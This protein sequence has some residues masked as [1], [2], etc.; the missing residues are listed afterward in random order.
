MIII[1]IL[2]TFLLC[3][4]WGGAVA[5]HANVNSS[6]IKHNSNPILTIRTAQP[7]RK[8][9]TKTVWWTGTVRSVN[10]AKVGSQQDG[11]IKKIYV[12]DNAAVKKGDKI[13]L[14]G[15]VSI[16]NQLHQLLSKSDLI[17]QK[18]TLTK[19]I[20]NNKRQAVNFHVLPT[21]ELLQAKIQLKQLQQQRKSI[22]IQIENIKS[23][24]IITSPIDGVFS[25]RKV[26]KGQ[27]VSK[28]TTLANV[29]DTH[30][31]RIIAKTFTHAQLRGCKAEFDSDGIKLTG[32][33]RNVLP[34]K[35]P[36]G[37]AIIYI[38]SNEIN[39]HCQIGQTLSGQIII[40]K[41]PTLAIPK[42]AM[43]YDDNENA[44]VFIETPTGKYIKHK[45]KTGS[46]SGKFIEIVSGIK[47][48]D[49][50]VVEGAYELFFAHFNKIYKVAD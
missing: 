49:K 23:Q 34:R 8:K 38:T 3:V 29:I 25:N 40:G 17:Q 6:N 5:L 11:I 20:L 30:H 39:R 32:I 1:A 13:F 50:I 18:I 9:F 42:S 27:L 28:F 35:T 4:Y 43:V 10:T 48:T 26:T 36:E 41:Y 15:G 45:I 31:L 37:A 33:V 44:F 19:Q 22:K 24:S 47:P 12:D 7:L 14:I 2:A 46:H 21:N 16:E